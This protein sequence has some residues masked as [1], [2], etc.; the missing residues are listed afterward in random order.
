MAK[1]TSWLGTSTL[2][3][4]PRQR[5]MSLATLRLNANMAAISDASWKHERRSYDYGTEPND[6]CHTAGDTGNNTYGGWR[7][8]MNHR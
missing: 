6:Y 1:H 5:N 3:Y 2:T 7:N 8:G 4:I